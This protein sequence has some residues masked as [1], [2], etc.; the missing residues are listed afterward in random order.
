MGSK[1]IRY[2]LVIL[3]VVLAMNTVSIFDVAKEKI[4]SMKEE[5]LHIDNQQQTAYRLS[6]AESIW[7]ADR[8][9]VYLLDSKT[10]QRHKSETAGATSDQNHFPIR[11][12]HAEV[13]ILKKR[14]LTKDEFQRLLPSLAQTI[15]IVE[16]TSG[17]SCHEPIHGLRIFTKKAL[18]FETNICYECNNFYLNYPDGH[19]RWIGLSTPDFQ[20]IMSSLCDTPMQQNAIPPLK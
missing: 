4:D 10:I 2:L 5:R 17:A 14:E 11:P 6:L 16:P 20:A 12:Y 8:C 13:K 1:I 18:I 3:A 15:S 7:A 9:E 19:S